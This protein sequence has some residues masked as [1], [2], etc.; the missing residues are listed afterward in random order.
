MSQ[1]DRFDS[2][3]SLAMDQQLSLATRTES[4]GSTSLQ[5]WSSYNVRQDSL[6][7]TES[8]NETRASSLYEC[9]PAP[10]PWQTSPK[11]LVSIP[12]SSSP[13]ASLPASRIATPGVISCAQCGTDFS[14]IYRR[15]N[16][17]R[18]V[19]HKHDQGSGKLFSCR[20]ANCLHDFRRPDARLKHERKLHPELQIAPIESRSGPSETFSE[21]PSSQVDSKYALSTTSRSEPLGYREGGHQSVVSAV[22]HDTSTDEYISPNMRAA[23]HTFAQLH[24]A[25]DEEDY[26]QA[27]D[28][29]F[30]RWEAIAQELKDKGSNAYDVYAQALDDIHSVI[31]AIDCTAVVD[32]SEQIPNQSEH[33][34]QQKPYQETG[35]HGQGAAPS[36]GSAPTADYNIVPQNHTWYPANV[37]SGKITTGRKGKGKKN[38]AP[39]VDCP[40]YKHWLLYRTAGAPPPCR[41]C[42][43][44]SMNQVRNHIKQSHVGERV[45]MLPYYHHCT[46][47]KG[48]FVDLTSG[49]FHIAARDCA[50]TPQLRNNITTPWA[51]L[52]LSIYP[53]ATQVPRPFTGEAGFLPR[54]VITQCQSSRP[55]LGER[56]PGN[57]R[58]SPRPTNMNALSTERPIYN[59]VMQTMLRE[60]G[61][62]LPSSESQAIAGVHFGAMDLNIPVGSGHAAF[63]EQLYNAQSH[64]L[65]VLLTAPLHMTQ[66]QIAAAAHYLQ[67]IVDVVNAFY[68]VS[69]VPAASTVDTHVS[70]E[71]P[72]NVFSDVPLS[73]QTDQTTLSNILPGSPPAFCGPGGSPPDHLAGSNEAQSMD[74]GQNDLAH[75][76][77][78]PILDLGSDIDG[79]GFD[80]DFDL[81]EEAL[82]Q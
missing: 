47:C 21:P 34:R 46:R 28:K 7:E 68:T 57:S 30:L 37:N 12:R 18:H 44:T 14:G 39:R 43:A 72:N 50:H 65:N 26:S 45:G 16:L 48:N 67:Q 35:R 11:V 51:Q 69:T 31:A 74:H 75:I 54:G 80:Q 55:F 17:A 61:S 56:T 23:W 13:L 20:A 62:H 60:A 42:S 4:H 8:T 24:A 6:T 78:P 79:S 41:G 27:C 77:I 15:G 49:S 76:F 9:D 71:N 5:P 66:E 1:R 63:E 53:S 64:L 52:Y 25:L 29:L 38:P 70:G 58:E 33:L 73:P 22:E 59:A 40:M 82:W 3:L 81:E 2:A 32:H 36:S 10:I 19:R